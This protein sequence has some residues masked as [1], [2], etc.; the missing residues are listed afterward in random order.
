MPGITFE[1][2]LSDAGFSAL[3]TARVYYV[4]WELVVGGPAVHNPQAWDTDTWLGIGHFQL[5]NDLT[6]AG[7]I[8]AIGYGDP[9]WM[10]AEVGQWIVEPGDVDGAFTSVIASY[11]RWTLSPGTSVHL[12]VFGA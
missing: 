9:H 4:A 6:D 12:Y 1:D 7:A 11:I 5:G 3:G 10:N 8:P 2:T